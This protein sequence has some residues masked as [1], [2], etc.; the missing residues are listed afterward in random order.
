MSTDAWTVDDMRRALERTDERDF[1]G[2]TAFADMT[3]AQRLDALGH[4]IAA[5]A[6]LKGL[7]RQKR[8]DPPGAR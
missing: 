5:V 8:T 2:H 6:D 1:D 3:P 7:V 4:M